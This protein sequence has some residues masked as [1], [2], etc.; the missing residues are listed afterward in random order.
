MSVETGN[1][2][3]RPTL[4]DN[5]R[6]GYTYSGYAFSLLGAH[7]RY[8]IVRYQLSESPDRDLMYVAPQ[9]MAW[10]N[11]LSL[12]TTLPAR[13]FTW[14]TINVNVIGSLR[15]FRLSHT[16]EKL[17][18]SYFTWSLN[19]SHTVT[20]P[21][22]YYIELSGWYNARQYDGSKRFQAFGTLN[23]GVKK[24]LKSNKGTIQLTVTDIFRSIHYTNNFGTLTREAFNIQS[25]VI[26]RPESAH[27]QIVKITYTRTLGRSTSSRQNRSNDTKDESDRIRRD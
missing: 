3:L 4:S 16:E 18:K 22:Q 25:H 12:Q 17:Q 5:V 19:S 27:A 15:Q 9:N 10:Q 7:D 11:S 2:T 26:Y 20:L 21:H 13:I 1:P 23:A 8:P 14:Y 24:E 6:V